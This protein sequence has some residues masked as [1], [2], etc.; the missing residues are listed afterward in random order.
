MKPAETAAGCHPNS[1]FGG[2]LTT[3]RDARQPAFY[4]L[5]FVP[6]RVTAGVRPVREYH[7][8]GL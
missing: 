3:P 5:F 8:L 7:G 1:G 2:S 4:P 6:R